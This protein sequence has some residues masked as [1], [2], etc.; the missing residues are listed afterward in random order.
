MKKSGGFSELQGIS[1]YLELI[2]MGAYTAAEMNSQLFGSF[3]ALEIRSKVASAVTMPVLMFQVL[4]DA[5]TK[6]PEDAPERQNK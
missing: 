6:N 1:Q 5:W 3:S 2:K 4:E